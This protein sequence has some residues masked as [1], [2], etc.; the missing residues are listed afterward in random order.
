MGLAD[1]ERGILLKMAPRRVT[2]PS[3]R[4]AILPAPLRSWSLLNATQM[5]LGTARAAGGRGDRSFGNEATMQGIPARAANLGSKPI[6]LAPPCLLPDAFQTSRT[7][8]VSSETDP[9]QT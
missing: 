7:S 5:D 4:P 3:M 9:K 8:S 6:K 1:L 2:H